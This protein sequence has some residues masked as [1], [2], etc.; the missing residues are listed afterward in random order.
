M[1][2]FKESFRNWFGYSR[3]ERRSTFILLN[4][5]VVIFGLRYIY[6][7]GDNSLKIIPLELLNYN[8]DSSLMIGDTPACGKAAGIKKSGQEE[9]DT[10]S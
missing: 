8:T 5:I 1:N 6:P 9:A 7:S 10:E 2:S 4:I 3:R